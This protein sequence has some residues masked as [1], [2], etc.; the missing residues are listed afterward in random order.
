MKKIIATLSL[1]LLQFMAFAQSSPITVEKK[2]TGS[3]VILL[4]GFGCPGTVWNETVQHLDGYQAHVVSYAGFNH[5]PAIDTPWYPALREALIGYIKK[6]NLQKIHLIGHSMG[7]NLAVEIA[8]AMPERISKLVIVDAL[9]CMR[10]LMMPGIS[11]SQISYNNPY[12]DQLL[13]MTKE[14]FAKYVKSMADNMTLQPQASDTIQQWMINADRKT[15]V[16]GYT[17][18]LKLDLRD[19]LEKIT[20]P[21]LIL[22]NSFPD[23]KTTEETFQKQYARLKQKE[24]RIADNSRHFIMFD[25]PEWMYSNISNFFSK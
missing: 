14:P 15:F 1:A 25:Q 6:E 4:P 16:Y 9:S 22:G 5:L 10:E 8:A 20:A 13:A 12:N 3:P 21:V 2:G 19:Q 17:D 23:K 18:L 7:G 24:I 11:A